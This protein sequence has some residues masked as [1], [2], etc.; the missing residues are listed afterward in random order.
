MDEW[1]HDAEEWLRHEEHNGDAA[2]AAF[3]RMFAAL[4][5]VVPSP[6]FAQRAATAAWSARIR[7]RR[8]VAAGCAAA[9]VAVAAGTALMLAVG[10]PA[11]LLLAGTH[12]AGNSL[13]AL[14]FSAVGVAGIWTEMIRV[15][16]ALAQVL[17]MPQSIAAL[18]AI[19]SIG[20]VALYSLQRLLRA[21]V[22][23]RG[24][25]LVCV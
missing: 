10:A 23:M 13:T 17:V 24:Q 7:R 11:W 14:L 1:Q 4:P 16:G 18:I 8:L 20:I 19:E 3:G 2:E 9:A 25:G 5:P 15:G 12:I 21:D 22:K 6:G